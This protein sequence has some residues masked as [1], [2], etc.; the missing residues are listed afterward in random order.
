MSALTGQ[1]H[2][3]GDDLDSLQVHNCVALFQIMPSPW[4]EGIQKECL[5]NPVCDAKRGSSVKE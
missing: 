5:S 3:E 4:L 2:L 1:G